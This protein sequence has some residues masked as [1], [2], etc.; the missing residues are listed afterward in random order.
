MLSDDLRKALEIA[1]K[2]RAEARRLRLAQGLPVDQHQDPASV[3]RLQNNISRIHPSQTEPEQPTL[4]E[5]T[6]TINA[7]PAHLGW[8]N[9]ALTELVRRN[10]EPKPAEPV[11]QQLPIPL[12]TSEPTPDVPKPYPETVKVYPSIA[13]AILR[14]ES[15]APARIYFLLRTIDTNGRGCLSLDLIQDEL[16][17]SKKPLRIA[18]AKTSDKNAWR[19]LRGLLR[20]GD[21]IFWTRDEENN[22]LWLHSAAR[23]AL[24]MGC[25]QIHGEPIAVPVS[26]FVE[27]IQQVRA[28][29]Y[30]S[31]HAGREKINKQGRG[32]DR[33][34]SQASLLT[35]TAVS[36]R[37]QTRYN[38][39]A[40][41]KVRKNYAIGGHSDDDALKE[42][43][44]EKWGNAFTF[45]D[46]KGRHGRRG[47]SYVASRLPNSYHTSLLHVARGRHSKINDIL[48][49]ID[50]VTNV[51]EEGAEAE[52][53]ASSLLTQR[54]NGSGQ[55]NRELFYQ[56]S[57]RA[58]KAS[59]HERD[60]DH[61]FI[62]HVR[63]RRK[64]CGF[65]YEIPALDELATEFS[66]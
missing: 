56:D 38:E 49:D 30:A 37:T 50:L 20:R 39:V 31:F 34:I 1:D 6:E 5:L 43:L 36:G 65:W 24:A 23:I 59:S 42:R 52:V 25:K 10:A 26:A 46:Y 58:S 64:Q 11:V 7:L 33:P 21:G 48:Q 62:S 32:V 14:K 66:K 40:K 15:S 19:N 35:V 13:A 61:F 54:G 29:L 12:E 55:D 47:S 60:I 57:K 51:G 3:A 63:S 53:S 9:V 45:K 27:G 8:H 18:K 41:L 4:A 17:T 16:T 28:Y 2:K 22:C 44:C